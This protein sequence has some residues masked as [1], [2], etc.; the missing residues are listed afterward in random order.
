MHG[1]L[2]HTIFFNLPQQQ[3]N[4]NSKDVDIPEHPAEEPTE[5][6]R[7]IGKLIAEN[8]VVDGCVP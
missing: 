6:E 8:L 2:T 1:T 5:V 7:A 3:Q 4:N